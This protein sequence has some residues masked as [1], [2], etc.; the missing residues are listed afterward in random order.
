MLDSFGAV[1]V[2]EAKITYGDSAAESMMI[3][4]VGSDIVAVARMEQ[5]IREHGVRFVERVFT[6]A[7][8][9]Y[10]DARHEPAQAYAA[11]FAAKEACF[12]ALGVGWPKQSVS[13]RDV[14]V[15]RTVSGAPEL[16]LS[17]R[18]GELASERGVVRS[19]VSLSHVEAFALAMVILEA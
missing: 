19:W 1:Q 6:Q 16:V 15:R 14:E 2:H 8:A 3:V 10:A 4:G 7:E 18:L 9:A 5:A 12:K 11:R 13:W 17:G